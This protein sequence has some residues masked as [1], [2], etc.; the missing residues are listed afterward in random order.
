MTGGAAGGADGGLPPP[1]GEPGADGPL[2]PMPFPLS[3]MPVASGALLF[4]VDVSGFG[5]GLG[6]EMYGPEAC[7]GRGL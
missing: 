5:T 1:A 3:R 4:V 7:S 6:S 2:P